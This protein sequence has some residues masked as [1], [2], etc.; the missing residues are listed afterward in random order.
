MVQRDLA[1]TLRGVCGVGQSRADLGCCSWPD[2]AVALGSLTSLHRC[3]L[4]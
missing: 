4:S 3:Q 1:E 2:R